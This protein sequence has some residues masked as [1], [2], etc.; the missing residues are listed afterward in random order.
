MYTA[1]GLMLFCVAS[2]RIMSG[3]K[4]AVVKAALAGF[5][6]ALLMLLSP[7]SLMAFGPW[8]LFRLWKQRLSVGR[9]FQCCTAFGAA[10]VIGCAP[11]T[12]RNSVQLGE[13]VFVRDDFG[14]AVYSC[15]NDCA[16][17][18]WMDKVSPGCRAYH[19]I[20]SPEEA[21]LVVEMGEVKYNASR[22][23]IAMSWIHNHP[24]RFLELTSARFIQFWFP[25]SEI[26]IAGITAVS[27]IGLLWMASGRLPV[28]AYF[29]AVLL[30]Y[31]PVYY[32][33]C[34]DVRYRYPILWISLLCAGYLLHRLAEWWKHRKQAAASI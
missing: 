2:H 25:P 6:G 34:S 32:L 12:I 3:S 31:P 30:A 22:L 19:P 23:R 26:S 21:R 15:N 18:N 1:C 27:L 20:A 17:P 28:A 16:L 8:M 10:L 33:V 9:A 29:S 24:R 4:R 14:L 7:A 13:L 5:P 11:W